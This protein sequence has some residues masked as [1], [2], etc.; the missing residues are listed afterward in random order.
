MKQLNPLTL[1]AAFSI[2]TLFSLT[3]CFSQTLI[4]G[5]TVNDKLPV[6]SPGVSKKLNP[7]SDAKYDK[8][9]A[10]RPKCDCIG[11]DGNRVEAKQINGSWKVVDRD[12]W[13]LD[14]AGNESNAQLSAKTIREYKMNE[15]CF[16]GRNTGKPMMFFLSDGQAP[17]AKV[18]GEDAIQF[19]NSQVK[20][21][22]INGS[23][24][25]TC[26]TMWMKDF[27]TNAEAAKEAAEQVKYYGFTRQCFIGRPGAPMEYYAK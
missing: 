14:F 1:A 9:T 24:K 21:E 2:A 19:D 20:A 25:L 18:E 5:V 13:I 10:Q 7:M 4:G 26:G 23:W 8:T 17:Q 6:T 11:F 22:E 12:H 27:D 3:P 16:V 15:I